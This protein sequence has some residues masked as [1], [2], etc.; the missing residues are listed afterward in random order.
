[1]RLK[2]GIS[3]LLLVMILIPAILTPV[4]ATAQATI[5]P[6]EFDLI[7]NVVGVYDFT[8]T[9]G[10]ENHFFMQA[11]NN[12][13]SPLT[14]IQFSADM[15]EGWTVTFNPN[16]LDTLSPGSSYTVDVNVVPPRT[17]SSREFDITLIAESA[18]TRAVTSV[19][20]RVEGPNTFW[21]W[22]GVGITALVII[23][24]IIIFLRFGRQ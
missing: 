6:G 22:V 24:F 18:E 7:L 3:L 4:P 11:R 10:K 14:N 16:L 1:M 23:A 2:K 19:F 20:L 5:P 17:V 15:S 8:I 9:P 13:T 12:G 21:L